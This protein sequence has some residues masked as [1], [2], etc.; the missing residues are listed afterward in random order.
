M[1]EVTFEDSPWEQALNALGPGDGINALE[2]LTLL[3]GESEV[4]G[5]QAAALQK[6][7]VR[8]YREGT[9]NLTLLSVLSLVVAWRRLARKAGC[10]M[11]GREAKPSPGPMGMKMRSLAASTLSRVQ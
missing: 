3:E 1:M 10:A 2:L 8:G 7:D 4:L 11:S 6:G 5:V 9:G